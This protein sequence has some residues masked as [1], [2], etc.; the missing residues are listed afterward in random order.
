MKRLLMLFLTVSLTSLPCV[1]FVTCAKDGDQQ[2][3]N[4][5]Y[6]YN[7]ADKTVRNGNATIIGIDAREC[8]CCGGYF[9]SID[10]NKPVGGPY[11]FTNTFPG[12]FQPAKYPLRVKIEWTR[13]ANDCAN[14]KITI[15]S[16]T[17]LNS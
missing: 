3:V 17:V 12:D 13:D 15:K 6:S 8:P 5:D 10:G 16:I 7:S 9:L 11:F 1:L 2:T 4:S 14:D